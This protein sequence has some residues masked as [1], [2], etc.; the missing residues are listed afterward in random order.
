VPITRTYGRPVRR[1]PPLAS[2]ARS[3]AAELSRGRDQ[4]LIEVRAYGD[5]SD[6][7]EWVTVRAHAGSAALEGRPADEFA[8]RIT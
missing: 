8:K 7:Q 3:I 5:A 4:V 2:F 6:F 1:A